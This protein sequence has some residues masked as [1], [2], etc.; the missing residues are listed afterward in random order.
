MP[1]TSHAY[2]YSLVNVGPLTAAYAAPPACATEA[3][4]VDI[5]RTNQPSFAEYFAAGDLSTRTLGSCFPSGAALDGFAA[6]VAK[7]A[8]DQVVGYFSPG[9]V[10]PSGWQT[11]GVAVKASD[12]SLSTSGAFDFPGSVT[13]TSTTSTSSSTATRTGAGATTAPGRSLWHGVWNPQVNVLMGAMDHGETAVLC[14]PA[15]MTA[16]TMGGCYSTLPGYRPTVGVRRVEPKGIR[17]TAVDTPLSIYGT[18]LRVDLLTYTATSPVTETATTTFRTPTDW[19]GITTVPMVTL[20]HRATDTPKSASGAGGR[21]AGGG[22]TVLIVAWAV[23]VAVG[24]LLV[25][26]M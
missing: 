15:S 4:L 24:T 11:A 26:P 16:N 1:T 22:A 17:G 10:C 23:A 18:T 3:R 2:Q 20:V 5:A 19:V 6:R 12:G 9:V 25:A 13:S 8:A 7:N 21:A 14:C